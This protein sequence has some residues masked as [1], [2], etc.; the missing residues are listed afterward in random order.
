MRARVEHVE[1]RLRGGEAAG[2]VLAL[3]ALEVEREREIGVVVPGLLTQ[4]LHAAAQ[5]LGRG[6]VRGR[7]LGPAPRAHVEPRRARPL[8]RIGDE[9]CAQAVVVGD[10]EELVVGGSVARAREQEP[11]DEEVQLLL[12]G[13]RDERVGRLLHAVVQ[14]AV[15]HVE[16]GGRGGARVVL[17]EREAVVEAERDDEPLAERLPQ[18]PGRLV[19]A[20]GAEDGERGEV[21]LVADARGELEHPA[22]LGREAL[23]LRGHEVDHVVG[24]LGRRD[25][26]HVPR[27]HAERAVEGDEPAVGERAEELADEERVAE[28]LLEDDAG[29]LAA[30]R[31]RAPERVRHELRHVVERERREPDLRRPGAVPGELREGERE[32]VRGRDLVVAVGPDQEQPAAL[33]IGDEEPDQAERRRVD[34]LEVVEEDD[35]RLIHGEDADEA[36][37]REREAVL[38][39][40]GGQRGHRLRGADHQRDLGDEID[41]DLADPSQRREEP[42]LPARQHVGGLREDLPHEVAERVRDGLV[43]RA[44]AALV[45]LPRDEEAAPRGHAALHLADERRLADARVADHQR[46]LCHAPVR[47][48]ERRL[49]LRDLNLAA[50]ELLRELEKLDAVGEARRQIGDDAVADQAPPA[51]VE[52]GDDAV[53]ALVTVLRV[54]GHQLCHDG[55]ERARDARARLMQ[56]LRDDGDVRVH[57]LDGHVLREGQAPGEQLVEHDAERVEVGAVIDAAVHAPRLLGR[58]VGQRP[59][60]PVRAPRHQRL[61]REHRGDREVDE[62]RL[63]RPLVED[64]VL[65][66]DVLVN[67]AAA[68]DLGERPGEA[69]G[70]VEEIGQREGPV[71]LHVLLERGVARVLQDERHPAGAVLDQV[72]DPRQPWNVE[73]RQDGLLVAQLGDPAPIGAFGGGGLEHDGA[74]V[75][76]PHRAADDRL[77]PVMDRRCYAVSGEVEHSRNPRRSVVRRPFRRFPSKRCRPAG[78]NGQLSRSSRAQAVREPCAIEERGCLSRVASGTMEAWRV[79]Q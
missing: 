38:R 37:E 41:E 6:L 79:R 12:A 11:P 49:E 26:R 58:D 7:R 22:R 62:P 60:Q 21:E 3:G 25:A 72:E 46:E 59:L 19:R 39:L 76:E 69:H 27:P 20:R 66:L 56:R 53:R 36:V 57:Q 78:V 35:E 77:R 29:E 67:H 16:G 15:R 64:D 61:A 17:R 34:P 18:L 4:Q 55:G 14:E 13:R 45:E 10:V 70:D 54:L 71:R 75:R 73:P 51:G 33:R 8:G 5:V 43:G 24:D 2:E 52:V 42:R 23:D 31:P 30:L 9:P 63:P 74:A 68:V 44:A 48:R 1:E 32:R 50:V 65:R 40:G 28:R 47:A